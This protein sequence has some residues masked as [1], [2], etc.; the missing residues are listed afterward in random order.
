MTQS[1]M[2]SLFLQHDIDFGNLF[3]ISFNEFVQYFL[4]F[5]L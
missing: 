2:Q 4:K 3:Y 1:I 5:W